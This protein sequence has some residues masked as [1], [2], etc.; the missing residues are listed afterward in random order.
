M[1]EKGMIRVSHTI[2]QVIEVWRMVIRTRKRYAKPHV[3]EGDIKNSS[4]LISSVIQ[5]T[6]LSIRVE[7]RITHHRFLIRKTSKY[8]IAFSTNVVANRTYKRI[9]SAAPY[10]TIR[11]N[12]LA[13]GQIFKAKVKALKMKIFW[14]FFSPPNGAVSS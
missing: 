12:A 10:R 14:S 3:W 6:N 2:Q 11:P 13:D 7:C 8:I 1:R 5:L 4:L 9:P